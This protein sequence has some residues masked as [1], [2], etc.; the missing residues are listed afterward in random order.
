[1]VVRDQH[2]VDAGQI[3]ERDSGRRVAADADEP[4]ERAAPG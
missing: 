3:V 1:V 2:E 4:A